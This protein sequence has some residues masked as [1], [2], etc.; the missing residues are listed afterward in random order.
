MKSKV[1]NDIRD[2]TL[3]EINQVFVPL[4][5]PAAYE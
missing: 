2:M 1:L 5:L 3:D 4:E